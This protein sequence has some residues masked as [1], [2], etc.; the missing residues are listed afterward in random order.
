MGANLDI[1][2]EYGLTALM[3]CM[4]Y[5]HFE[6]AEILLRNGAIIDNIRTND[7]RTTLDCAQMN[8]NYDI[9]ELVLQELEKRNKARENF[10]ITIKEASRQAI[11]RFFMKC[12]NKFGDD[13]RNH[14]CKF[15]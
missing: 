5:N 10:Q 13:E 1:V 14:I 6:F 7:G 3:R 12:N 11:I 4:C 2:D 9:I 8:R 15:L